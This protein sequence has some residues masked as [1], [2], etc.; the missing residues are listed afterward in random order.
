M[1]FKMKGSPMK[2][3]FNIG[4]KIKKTVKKVIDVTSPSGTTGPR[5]YIRTVASKIK[6]K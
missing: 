3:N 1:A 2:R 5:D 6:G 4:D